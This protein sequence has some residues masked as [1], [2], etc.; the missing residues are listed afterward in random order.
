MNIHCPNLVILGVAK[1]TAQYLT[2][3]ERIRELDVNV[4][5]EFFTWRR[6]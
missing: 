6:C 1:I 2:Y 3:V 5:S 4:A